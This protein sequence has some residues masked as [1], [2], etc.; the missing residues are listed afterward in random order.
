MITRGTITIKRN[1]KTKAAQRRNRIQEDKL[2]KM[3]FAL[4]KELEAREPS[5]YRAELLPNGLVHVFDYATKW[6]ALYTP[7]GKFH[8]GEITIPFVE[9][10]R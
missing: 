1:L 6:Y 3:L 7:A 5:S 2:L 10:T 4:T 8:S 9:V